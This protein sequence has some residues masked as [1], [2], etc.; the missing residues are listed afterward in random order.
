MVLS[1]IKLILNLL[2]DT[3]IDRYL[4]SDKLNIWLTFTKNKWIG[5]KISLEWM[6]MQLLG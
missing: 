6:T 2:K 3:Y 4:S 5:G 1:S